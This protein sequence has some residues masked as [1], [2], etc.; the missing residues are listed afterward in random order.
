MSLSRKGAHVFLAN[1]V[2]LPLQLLTGVVVV[3][4]LG[5]EGK[6][7]LAVI[8]NTVALC[9]MIGHFSLPAAAIYFV[10][11]GDYGARLLLANYLPVVLAVSAIVAV[12]ALGGGAA[13]FRATLLP[14]VVLGTPLLLLGLGA[15]PFAMV[16]TFVTTLLLALGDARAYSRLVLTGGILTLGATAAFLFLFQWGLAGALL[17]VTGAQIVTAIWGMGMVYRRTY[18]EPGDLRWSVFRAL[19]GFG[20]RQHGASVSSQLFKRS[21][22][23]LLAYFLT[24]RAVGY[25]SIA[26]IAYEAILS[27]P[28]AFAHLLTGEAAGRA[29]TAAAALVARAARNMLWLM[30]VAALLVA[31]PAPWIV[32][33]IYGADF[34]AAV[35]PLLVLL[36]AAVLVGFTICLQTFFVGVGR[37]GLNGTFTLIAGVVNLV[38][39]VWWIPRYDIVG[40]AWATALGAVVIAA[41][42]L[43]GFRRLSH[44]PAR[45]AWMPRTEDLRFWRQWIL[46]RSGSA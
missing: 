44:L 31:I 33:L 16:T 3:R 7:T 15:V 2:V 30:L 21:D 34:S 41:L 5:A 36:L 9:A 11:R 19:F 37:P 8:A 35:A 25:Y 39:S 18:R 29:G 14:G 23:Y 24:P 32:P 20:L 10:R 42:H 45:L 28:R 22:T 17:A 12:L 4:A 27:I 40:N 1:W 6:G 38:L 43:E 13:W 26:S 46:S